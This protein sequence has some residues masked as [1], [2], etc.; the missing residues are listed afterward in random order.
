VVPVNVNPHGFL[1]RTADA[2]YALPDGGE[3]FTVSGAALAAGVMLKP[4]FRGSGY[5]TDQRN[6]GDFGSNVY[7]IEPREP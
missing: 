6:Q 5:T 2:H 1:V 4:L 3:D 7:V